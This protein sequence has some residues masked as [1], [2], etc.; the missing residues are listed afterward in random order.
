[1][2]MHPTLPIYDRDAATELHIYAS[3]WG[4]GGYVYLTAEIWKTEPIDLTT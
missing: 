1:M 4:L 3:K 2:S